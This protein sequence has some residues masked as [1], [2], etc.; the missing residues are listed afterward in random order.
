MNGAAPPLPLAAASERLK[1]LT[2]DGRRKSPFDGKHGGPKFPIRRGQTRKHQ[3]PSP[4]ELEA[5]AEMASAGAS[6]RSISNDLYRSEDFIAKILARPDVI[7]YMGRCREAI[8]S[9]TLDGMVK[10]QQ[11]AV[12]WAQQIADAKDDPKALELVTRS[13]SNMERVAASA[14]G[15]NKPASIVV[16]NRSVTITGD[17]ELAQLKAFLGVPV[18]VQ[19]EALDR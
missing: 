4:A 1:Q 8:R 15:E 12:T 9:V 6:R 3:V 5:V 10:I 2:K 7:A 18:T 11:D 13:M 19:A 14:S 17:E 16:D